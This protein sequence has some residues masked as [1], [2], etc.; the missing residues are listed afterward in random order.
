MGRVSLRLVVATVFLSFVLFFTGVVFFVTQTT[1]AQ[2]DLPT[3]S[4]H[5]IAAVREGETAVIMVSI[6]EPLSTPLTLTLTLV[7]EGS[8]ATRNKDYTLAPDG[9]RIERGETMAVIQVPTLDGGD[10]YLY[11]GDE[12]VVLELKVNENKVQFNTPDVRTLTI[13]DMLP[14]PT[15]KL[16]FEGPAYEGVDK[17]FTVNLSHA[18]DLTVTV[19]VA[20]LSSS[21]AETADYTITPSTFAIAAGELTATFTLATVQDGIYEFT[22]TLILEPQASIAAMALE[23]APDGDTTVMIAESDPI[24]TVSVSDDVEIDEDAGVVEFIVNLNG[25]LDTTVTL[26][27]GVNDRSTADLDDYNPLPATFEIA[28][29][30][31]SFTITLEIT[32]DEVYELSETL[33]LDLS[34]MAQALNLG[35][36]ARVV[37]IR[38]D[39]ELPEVSLDTV[40]SLSEGDRHELTV[41]L[42]GALQSTAAVTLIEQPGGVDYTLSPA[43]VMVPPGV[44]VAVF[45]L[46]VSDDTVY[47]GSNRELEFIPILDSSPLGL[48]GVSGDG[49]VITVLDNDPLPVV[50]FDPITDLSEGESGVITARLDRVTEFGFTL[51][52]DITNSTAGFDFA[53]DISSVTFAQAQGDGVLGAEEIITTFPQTFRIMRD[54][55]LIVLTFEVTNDTEVEVGEA[56][57]LE[58]TAPNGDVVITPLGTQRVALSDN[59]VTVGADLSVIGATEIPEGEM[60]TIEI[61]LDRPLTQSLADSLVINTSYQEN[62]FAGSNFEDISSEE[63]VRAF[64]IAS[65]SEAYTQTLGFGFQF[66]TE[67]YDTIA[68]H[69]NGLIGFTDDP[70]DLLDNTD[71]PDGYRGDDTPAIEGKIVP[72]VAPLLSPINYF[73]P[74]GLDPAPAFYGVRLGA[75]TDEDR[76]IVQYTNARVRVAAGVRYL[77]T[78]QVALY[79]DGRIELRYQDV[80][81]EVQKV[82]KIGISNGSGTGMYEEFSYRA[83]KLSETDTRIVYTPA[84]RVNAVIKDVDGET[85]TDFGILDII[86]V[87]EVRGMIQLVN[88]NREDTNWDGDQAYRVELVSASPLVVFTGTVV[89]YRF[90]DDDLPEVTLEYVCTAVCARAEVAEGA[91]L[92]LVAKLTNA[93][94]T[95]APEAVTV[96]LEIQGGTAAENLDYTLP[97]SITIAEGTTQTIFVFSPTDDNLAERTEE[98]VIGISSVEYGNNRLQSGVSF[99]VFITDNDPRRPISL[100]PVEPIIEGDTGVVTARLDDALGFSLTV[101]LIATDISANSPADYDLVT[102]TMTIPAGSLT[103]D[104]EVV[105]IVDQL[106]EEL[107]TFEL[108]LQVPPETVG[109]GVDAT[110]VVTILDE[111]HLVNFLSSEEAVLEGQELE[112]RL[113]A[114]GLLGYDLTIDI[115]NSTAGF[116]FARDITSVKFAQGQGDDVLGAQETVESFPRTFAIMSSTRLIT[117]TFE[118]ANDT[119][120]E[121]GESFT[122]EAT[123]PNGYVTIDSNTVEVTLR[124]YIVAVDLSVIGPTDIPEGEMVTIGIELDRPL[125]RFLAD[126]LTA[127]VSYQAETFAVSN[128]ENITSLIADVRF[129]NSSNN[130]AYLQP[131]GFD[132]EFYGETYSNIA[133][134]TNGFVGFTDDANDLIDATNAF[135]GRNRGD[136]TPAIEGKVVPIVA[137]LLS[138]IDP[139]PHSFLASRDHPNFYGVHLGAGTAEER[140]IVQYDRSRLNEQPGGPRVVAT[141][142]VALYANGRIEFRYKDIPSA[143]QEAAK[144]GI[145]NGTET[146]RYEEFSYLESKLSESDV[147]IVYTPVSVVDVVI[148]DAD[149]EAVTS[150]D[151]LDIIPV[152]GVKGAIELDNQ[153]NTDWDG[154]RT[155]TAELDSASPLFVTGTVAMYSFTEDDLPE[156]I[157]EYAMCTTVCARAEVAEGDSLTLIVRLTNAPAGATEAV[158][159][160]LA[161]LGGTATESSD[162]ALPDSITIAEG[163]YQTTFT[164]SPID[165]NL[166]E[167]TE[168]LTIGIS[169][170]EY[171]GNQL[172]SDA[173]FELLITDDES[174]PTLSLELSELSVDEGSGVTVTAVLSGAFAEDVEVLLEVVGGTAD[175]ADYSTPAIL[176]DTIPARETR[177]AFVITATM[178]RIYEGLFAETLQLRLSVPARPTTISAMVQTLTINDLETLP[179]LSL[180]GAVDVGEETGILRLTVDLSGPLDENVEL[181]LTVGG[182]VNTDDYSLTPTLTILAGASSGVFELRTKNDRIYEGTE[183]VVLTLSGETVGADAESLLPEIAM[184]RIIDDEDPAQITVNPISPVSEGET[185]EVEVV[186]TTISAEDVIVTLDVAT[187][188]DA[189][190]MDYT[191]PDSLIETIVAGD[192]MATFQ[193][194]TTPNDRLYEG[195]ET[196][197][198]EFTALDGTVAATALIRD[199]DEAPTV[200]FETSRPVTVAEGSTVTLLVVLNG[201]LAESDIVVDFT[202]SGTADEGVDYSSLERN[203]TIP[204]GETSTIVS[205]FAA[206]DQ[207]TEGAETLELRLLYASAGVNV[208]TPNVVDVTIMD[209]DIVTIGFA[210]SSYSITE[211]SGLREIEIEVKGGTLAEPLTVAVATVAGTA[212]APDDYADTRQE[213]VLSA[214][215]TRGLS[216]YRLSLIV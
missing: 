38:N 52:L 69:T 116:D 130:E 168:N 60:V 110:R 137:P 27:L 64:S 177:V 201:T 42:S 165:D 58:A 205:I 26:S 94:P 114:K 8:T 86:A 162:Y 115:A 208:A 3:I 149:G 121:P 19:S 147:R 183:T 82:A 156:V 71:A 45:T 145:S 17:D 187:T 1:G 103:A 48:R 212:T 47:Q 106:S 107:E 134:H 32:A 63:G 93:A 155:Y 15:L 89:S 13:E 62:V 105:T 154:T 193:I 72:I 209:D 181:T 135:R 214:T 23:S 159:V 34:F 122:L 67:I 95:G 172:Q 153:E 88:R 100:D 125:T 21:K 211:N 57:T 133:V 7:R 14:A 73:N 37:T 10:N 9:V 56:F 74:V 39:E 46:D 163:T 123:S 50:V 78:F 202:V 113:D 138:A 51:T 170:V 35:M 175:T 216:Q 119:E 129:P 160:N 44:T 65:N 171:G 141:F 24:P 2:S 151:I 11:E 158:T 80:P 91:S 102:A 90:T 152:A 12:T 179:N 203:V 118:V 180:N 164:F 20:T 166:A 120:V 31:T 117:L 6:N 185:I 173:R 16:N 207:L 182:D 186:L 68:V 132:F 29:R 77:A 196:I 59:V 139:R 43:T 49:V 40:G 148:K 161:D 36:F 75:G 33:E 79:A 53:Q 140:Y 194:D 192:R 200:A 5:E 146:R 215:D 150:F 97:V 206:D 83:S 136:E 99:V 85:F 195:A 191:L 66:Y 210:L 127:G 184:F 81:S 92:T 98:L 143:A 22:E 178:D 198:L 176:L 128:F 25:A 30:A 4:F 126:N 70:D 213:I 197:D 199:V 96:N 109:L 41:R 167:E 131:L 111:A 61:E 101:T 169:S 142:Q 124:D 174:R 76:Y 104:F 204:S 190:P 18:A 84:S 157:L 188:G 108:S 87:D 189:E 55:T 144:I 112:V 28:P 54:T